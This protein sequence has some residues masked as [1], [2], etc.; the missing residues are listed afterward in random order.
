MTTSRKSGEQEAVEVRGYQPAD[1]AGVIEVLQAAFGR[2]P[3]LIESVDPVEFFRWKTAECPFGASVSLVALNDRGVIGFLGQLPWLFR[4]HGRTVLSTR[5]VDLGVDPSHRRRGISVAMIR[6]AIEN[7][8]SDVALA[9]NNPNEQS[10][11]GL[12]KT[13]RRKVVIL[14]RF[15]QPRGGP[16]QTLRRASGKGSRT[17][18]ELPVE[19]DTA[20]AVL[21]DGDY[22]SQ[23]LAETVEPSDRLVTARD[24][25]YLRW[26]YGRFGGY[27]G[28]RGD[29]GVDAPGIV[30]FRLHRRESLWVCDVCELL[31][32]GGEPASKRRLLAKVRRSAASDFLRANFASHLEALRCGFVRAS[33]GTLVT[34]RK[35]DDNLGVEPTERDA[36][37]LSLGDVDLL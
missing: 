12:M 32:A 37:A 26:R 6:A 16:G 11:P 5:G 13:E 9:W 10:R 20:A 33:G 2:W 4:V 30:I 22:V 25:D 23:L 8:L 15:V 29:T 19:A 21:G 36:W 14:P 1:E 17:P 34:A 35:I 7:H 31:V 18:E 3:R 28:F 27:H 24:L